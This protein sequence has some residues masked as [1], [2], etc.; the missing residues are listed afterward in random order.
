VGLGAL[1]LSRDGRIVFL[2]TREGDAQLYVMDGDGRNVRKL[3]SGRDVVWNEA[4][5]ISQPSWSPHG[6]KIAFDGQSGAGRPDCLQH[7]AIWD[8]LVVDSDG[9]GLEQVALSAR[10]PAWSSDG[11]R[12]AFES[13]LDSYGDAGSV[14]IKRLDSSGSVQVKAFNHSSDVGPVWSPTHDELAFQAGPGDGSSTSIYV[15]RGDGRRTRRLARGH[16]PVWSPGG[17]RLAFMHDYKLMT[18]NRNGKARRRLSRKGELV[19]GAAWSP[20]GGTLAFLAGTKANRFG[21]APT[22]LRIETV[23]ADGK[24]V[25]VLARE[26][27]GSQLGAARLDTGR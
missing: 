13:D 5:D 12:L 23:S 18:V 8:V 9:S 1:A 15:V 10:A 14:T 3:T 16:N 4:L 7:C 22:N 25:H 20:R 17:R 11:R 6:D 19:V 21:G 27:A 26:T 24:R 2:S